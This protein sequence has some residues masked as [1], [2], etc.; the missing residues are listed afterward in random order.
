MTF[1][2][3]AY[4]SFRS[5]RSETARYLIDLNADATVIDDAGQCCMTHMITNMGPVVRL[6]LLFLMKPVKRLSKCDGPLLTH[7]F[8][9]LARIILFPTNF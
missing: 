1:L 4:D 2:D 7:A 8:F 3:T 9:C 5:D 6:V